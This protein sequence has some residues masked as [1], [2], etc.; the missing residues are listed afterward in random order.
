MKPNPLLIKPLG[1]DYIKGKNSPVQ[2]KALTYEWESHL[3]FFER[4]RNPNFETDGCELFTSQ[5]S[6]DAQ[7]DVLMPTFPKYLIDEITSMGFMDTGRDGQPHFHSSPRFLEVLTGNG[8][9]GNTMTSAW[10]VMRQYGVI[11]WQDLPFTDTMG[12]DEYFL[13]IPQALLDKGQ[14]FIDLIGTRSITGKSNAILYHWISYANP[15]NLVDM[16]NA[17]QQAPLCLGIATVPDFGAN[18]LGWDQAIPADPLATSLPAHAVLAYKIEAPNVLIF[19]HYVPFEK[20]LD[21]GY[22]IP[23]VFQGVVNP[24]IKII[25]PAPQPPANPTIPQVRSWL[26]RLVSWLN[27]I[28]ALN[29]KGRE[30]PS[31]MQPTY[32]LLKS[33][34]FWTLVFGFVYQV[35]QLLQPSIP[36]TYSGLIDFVLLSAAAYFHLQTGK[37]TS[38]TN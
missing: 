4:Q 5:E 36:A 31:N 1:A 34:T 22:P 26:S 28:L 30:S 13:P 24:L 16:Q 14:R 2:F 10:D 3:Q 15:R 35:W 27:T 23:Y 12:Q 33:R 37:S 11:P 7:M 6:F 38:G 25:P 32:S 9:K 17:I 21:V 8:T 29:L 18:S 20:T 19:D